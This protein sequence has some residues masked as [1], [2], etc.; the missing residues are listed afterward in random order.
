M[1]SEGKVVL[2][3]GAGSGIGRAVAL[4]FAQAGYRLAVTGRRPE[5]LAEVVKEAG[6]PAIAIPAAAFPGFPCH[7]DTPRRPAR[8]R[9]RL[10]PAP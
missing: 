3:T 9:G 5:P 10:R 7:A 8:P 2:V 4:A 1:G 6:A